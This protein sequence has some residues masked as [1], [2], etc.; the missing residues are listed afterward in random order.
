MKRYPHTKPFASVPPWAVDCPRYT[1]TDRDA[2][3]DG[4]RSATPCARNIDQHL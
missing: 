3:G 1:G 4:W 2:L